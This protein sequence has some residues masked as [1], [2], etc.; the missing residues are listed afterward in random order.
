MTAWPI[1]IDDWLNAYRENGHHPQTLLSDLLKRLNP[2]DAAWITLCTQAKLDEQL[3]R[4]EGVGARSLPLYGVPFA[5]K[6][7]IDIEGWPTTAACPE[8]AYDARLTATIV[9]RLQAAGAVVIGKTNLDQFATGLVGAR[10]PYGK[11]PNTFNPAYVSG[12]SSSGSASVVARGLVPFSLGTDTA[13]SG[14]VP[15]GFNNLVGMKPTPGTVPMYGVLP[16]CKTLDVVSVFALTTADA[17]RVLGLM[18]GPGDE[19][20]LKQ[21]TM[22]AP[23]LGSCSRRLRVGIPRVHGCNVELGYA[24][25]FE[26]AVARLQ[27]M[28]VEVVA[29]DM[30]PLHRVARL[31]YDG[32]WVAERYAVVK[33]LM[34]HK[35]TAIDPVV[36]EVIGKARSFDARQAFEGRYQLAS[37]AHEAERTWTE[38]DVLMVPTAPTCPT[39]DELAQAP[40]VRNSELGQYTNFVN[41]LGWCALSLP[42]SICPGGLPF[43]VTFIAP[44]GADAALADWGPQ[45]EKATGLPAGAGLAAPQ[46]ATASAIPPLAAEPTLQLAVVGAH[47]QGLPL[48]E[49]LMER[50]CR[51]LQ[52]TVTAPN[53]RL[54]A[55]AG[56]Q[57]RKPGMIR[58]EQD[59]CSIEVE[60]YDMPMSGVG[61]FLQSIPY[62]LGLGSIE[63][64]DG[65]WVKG[66]I[67]D[68]AGLTHSL[69]ITPYGGWRNYLASEEATA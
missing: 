12:G 62:P 7:N 19:P 63:L 44:E 68:P 11:V 24:D 39:F 5:I 67:C 6:D 49:Q 56:T 34:D 16:A 17:T 40:V 65:S 64:S 50:R 23:W 38:V 53:Y 9:A 36:R 54:Y 28:G 27:A 3:A 21:V 32:P 30:E 37:L 25:A 58:V 52:A 43:G 41:L 31:L 46:A 66:F 42:S 47:L 48:H 22:R 18:Q 4:L 20:V 8:F 10:S 26:N 45:W 14:R 60:V 29:M 59:G 55:L 69:D 61:S 13:G 57:P 35:P 51:F 15:A 33:E 1:S 2:S